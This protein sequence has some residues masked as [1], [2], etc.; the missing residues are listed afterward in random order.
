MS[1]TEETKS[2]YNGIVIF[3]AHPKDEVIGSFDVLNKY[4]N[5]QSITIVYG[6]GVSNELQN[7]FLRLKEYFS[8]N[9]MI[10]NIVPPL[11]LSKDA[12]LFFPDPFSEVTPERRKWGYEGEYLARRGYNVIFYTLSK[13]V[14]YIYEINGREKKMEMLNDIYPD[15]YFKEEVIYEGYTKYLF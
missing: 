10:Q 14:P 9:Q 15:N 8:C 12:M 1:N 6:P 13:N 3:A 11:L 7:K 4:N 5:D 2:S